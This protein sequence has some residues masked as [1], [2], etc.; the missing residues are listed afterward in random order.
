MSWVCGS[1]RCGRCSP[2]PSR[3]PRS[4]RCGSA[5][6][7]GDTATFGIT[8]FARDNLQ[9][10]VFFEAPDVGDVMTK[11]QPYPPIESVEAVSDLYAPLSGEIVEVN[12][13]LADAAETINDNPYEQGWLIKVK[14]SDPSEANS[15]MSAAVYPLDRRSFGLLPEWLDLIPSRSI[16]PPSAPTALGADRCCCRPTE[17]ADGAAPRHQALSRTGSAAGRRSRTTPAIARRP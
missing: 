15:L 6:V 1:P 2:T 11:D 4:T 10:I 7:D 9:E 12:G 17:V 16:S 5:C 13:A 8:W 14:L 3:T